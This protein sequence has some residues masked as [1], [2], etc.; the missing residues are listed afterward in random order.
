VAR[1]AAEIL[2]PVICG[3][4]GRPSIPAHRWRY[5]GRAS[6]FFTAAALAPSAGPVV[7][8]PLGRALERPRG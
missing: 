1:R 3:A 4:I 7:E 2:D 5:P 6:M 8:Y